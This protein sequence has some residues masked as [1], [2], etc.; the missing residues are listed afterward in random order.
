MGERPASLIGVETGRSSRTASATA[1]ARAYHQIADEPRVFEDPLALRILGM[2]PD[3]LSERDTAT[4]DHPD[5]NRSSGQWGR[6]L[7]LGARARFAEQVVAEAVAD[8]TAQVVILGA[9]LD[10]FAYRNPYPGLRVFE[11]D[12]PATQAWKR[13]LLDEGGI[14][15][16]DSVA[17]APVDFETG[18]LADG[19]A[20]A[21]FARDESVVFVWLGVVMY[22]TMDAIAGTLRYIAEQGGTARVVL[23][24]LRSATSPAERAAQQARAELVASVGE[25]FR[26][27]F[28]PAEIAELLSSIGFTEIEDHDAPALI[29]GYL[30]APLP[31]SAFSGIPPRLV[32]ATAHRRS[33][34]RPYSGPAAEIPYTPSY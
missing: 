18:T 17:F 8:G 9:G 2:R 23:D 19:L 5:G 32:R 4:L 10:T 13:R 12:H 34:P 21:G 14:S 30:D 3:E 20:A 31:V 7:F 29:S 11:V 27:Y 6:R 26:S 15:V 22:L 33:R 1:H 16:P 25:P 28:T 24:Y